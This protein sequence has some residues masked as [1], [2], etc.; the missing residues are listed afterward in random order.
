MLVLARRPGEGVTIKVPG[1]TQ[2]IHF[3]IG[4]ID[5][6]CVRLVF[7]ADPRV[8]ILRDELLTREPVE[9]PEAAQTVD[10]RD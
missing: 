9:R 8:L 2:P 4:E 6:S 5:R 10:A 7:E 1:L 3:F